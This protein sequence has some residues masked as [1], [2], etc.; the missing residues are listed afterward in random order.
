MTIEYLT[1]INRLNIK[2]YSIFWLFSTFGCEFVLFYNAFMKRYGLCC[3]SNS[4]QRNGYKFR[5]MTFKR[6]CSL[7]RKDAISILCEIYANNLKVVSMIL[8]QCIENK[9]TYRV[10]SNIFP[11][12]THP[13]SNV[14]Y[15]E[16][17]KS[18]IIDS[19]FEKCAH[20]IHKN[21]IRISCHPDQ[22]NVLASSS[23]KSIE[24]TIRE[25][26]HQGWIMDRMGAPLN[27][28]API[29]I[30]INRSSGSPQEI[31][32]RFYNSLCRCS[33]SLQKRIVV[34]NEDKGIWTAQ[35][36]CEVFYP[37]VNIPITFDNLHHACNP[38]DWTEEFAFKSCYSTWKGVRPLFHYSESLP[39]QPNKRKHAEFPTKSPNGS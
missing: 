31:A 35:Q 1:N 4:C 9:W 20:K 30:H 10:S 2:T 21:R 14:V 18:D 3:I 15:R 26:D 16:L 13:D 38:S 28:N 27:R 32:E 29:N 33:E 34:E 19:L 7:D 12:L 11:L 5:T 24:S 17:P 23:E 36:L 6:F 39:K 37:I 8:D 25:L 22:F